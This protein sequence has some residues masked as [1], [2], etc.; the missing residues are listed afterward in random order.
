MLENFSLFPV[1]DNVVGGSLLAGVVFFH[2]LFDNLFFLFLCRSR[3]CC[4]SGSRSRLSCRNRGRLGCS[5]SSVFVC[6]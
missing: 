2:D 1:V 4:R 6:S 5:C 3:F